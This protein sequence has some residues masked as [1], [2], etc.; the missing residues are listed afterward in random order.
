MVARRF[1]SLEDKLR[2]N[3]EARQPGDS[4]APVARPAAVPGGVD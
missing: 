4:A 1:L 3:G 2:I